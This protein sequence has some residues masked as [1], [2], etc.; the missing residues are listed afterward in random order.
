MM[1]NQILQIKSLFEL[2]E[3]QYMV[4]TF[5]DTYKGIERSDN[6]IQFLLKRV[7]LQMDKIFNCKPNHNLTEPLQRSLEICIECR[8]Y[9]W[10]ALHKVR[11]VLLFCFY[12][13][14]VV[15]IINN[16]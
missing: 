1:S 7:S 13:Y 10:Q 11:Y 3:F 6:V 5:I 15:I 8:N 9:I 14:T 16:D 2:S 12:Y 4:S